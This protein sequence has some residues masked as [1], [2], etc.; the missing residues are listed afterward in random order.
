M[1]A[2]FPEQVADKRDPAQPGTAR[3]KPWSPPRVILTSMDQ[4]ENAL[5]VNSDGPLGS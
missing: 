2:R 1:I 5:T 3:A 4:T